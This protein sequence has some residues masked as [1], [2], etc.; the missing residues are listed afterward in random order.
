MSYVLVVCRS[1]TYAQRAS[2]LLERAGI[3]AIVM[4]APPGVTTAG[5]GY[6]I[7]LSEKRLN[8]ALSL[9]KNAGLKPGKVYSYAPGGTVKEV[10]P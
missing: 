4:K 3:T 10:E 7:K 5:C 6:C 8:D 2:R 1:L 9:L